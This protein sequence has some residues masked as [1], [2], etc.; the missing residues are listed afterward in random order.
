MSYI[1]IVICG[2]IVGV[3]NI[4]PGV[5]GGTMAV[6]LNIYDK[7]ISSIAD[8]FKDW[9]KNIKFL[10]PLLI[11]AGL[12]IFLFGKLLGFLLES[13]P[14]QVNFFFVGLILGSIPMISKKAMD[15]GA[16]LSAG[17][18]FAIGVGIMIFMFFVSPAEKS[19]DAA[20]STGLF[21]M[22]VISGFIGAIA[23]II[24]GISGSLMMLILGMYNIVLTA[25]G[26]LDVIK[27][28]PVAIGIIAG[29]L[30]GAK[31]IKFCMSRFPQITYCVILGLVVG[32]ILSVVKEAGFEWGAA[33]IVS[34][35]LMLVGAG[36]AFWMS[37][38]KIADDS[39]DDSKKEVA[40][41]SAE[42]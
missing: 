34:L 23:M 28:L 27:L 40:E 22:L 35:V 20:M 42:K 15:G 4:I 3:A 6:V 5:S 10:L 24:P 25:V 9:K 2:M 31:F 8:F 16:N 41:V 36:L 32:S 39:D 38:L 21:V 29:L 13:Y 12:G 26:N 19:G 18:A 37:K 11:G 17:I 1:W 14:M 7:V 30:V 33:G